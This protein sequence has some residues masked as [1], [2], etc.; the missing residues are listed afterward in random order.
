MLTHQN[1]CNSKMKDR[2][3]SANGEKNGM[4]T[5]RKAVEEPEPAQVTKRTRPSDDGSPEPVAPPAT[6]VWRIPF[7]EKVRYCTQSD[8]TL[9]AHCTGRPLPPYFLSTHCYLALYITIPIAYLPSG[10]TIPYHTTQ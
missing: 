1:A 2:T 7:P 6:E 4:A 5:K 9:V 8:L 3:E 10:H